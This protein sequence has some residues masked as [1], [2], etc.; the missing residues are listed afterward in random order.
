MAF[1]ADDIQAA[2]P[3]DFLGLGGDLFLVLFIQLREG[4]P[5]LEDL[6]VIGVAEGRG[7]CQHFLF[8]AHLPHLGLG[9]K[10]GIAAQQD[11]G[12]TAGHVGGDGN[13]AVSSGSGHN[14][15]L[16]LMELGIQHFM[17]NA[18]AF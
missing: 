9:H 17:R 12:T 2:Q 1:G 13:R 15:R 16:Q 8:I 3:A 14:L 18:A 4:L 5:G 6:L 7:L 11:I 10:L